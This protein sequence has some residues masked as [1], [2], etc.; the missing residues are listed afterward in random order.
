ME[1]GYI[2]NINLKKESQVEEISE[3]QLVGLQLYTFNWIPSTGS[4]NLDKFALKLHHITIK[5][6]FG[7]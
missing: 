5:D 7:S 4:L 3:F 6:I 1:D 2:Y